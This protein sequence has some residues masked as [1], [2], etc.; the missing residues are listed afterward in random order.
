[1]MKRL[2]WLVPLLVA[3]QDPPPETWWNNDWGFRRRLE[4]RNSRPAPLAKGTRVPVALYR[5]TLKD[6]QSKS[7]EDLSD[8]RL[9]YGGREVPYE[10]GKSV[11]DV[12]VTFALAAELGA[13][14][15]REPY[16][17]DGGYCLYYGNKA[18]PAP[19]YAAIDQFLYSLEPGKDKLDDKRIDVDG[20]IAGEVDG[21]GWLISGLDASAVEGAPAAARLKLST[22]LGD[23]FRWLVE[24][25]SSGV[26]P[27]AGGY[28]GVEGGM[29]DP[30]PGDEER[31]TIDGLITALGN[32]DF[33][34]REEAT[35]ALVK[36]GR[37][38]LSQ[39]R[40]AA[41]SDDLEVQARARH[42]IG[43]IEA[44]KPTR[45]FS[46]GVRWQGGQGVAVGTLA[47]LAPGMQIQPQPIGKPASFAL[48]VYRNGTQFNLNCRLDRSSAPVLDSRLN[49]ASPDE[50]RLVLWGDGTGRYPALRIKRITL[51]PETNNA[52]RPQ[53][54][55]DMED[56][57]P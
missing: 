51:A 29:G 4:L 17:A 26:D 36:M 50:L 7:K 52:T 54:F 8:F 11:D 45:L 44:K 42:V 22:K 47:T 18:A 39:V 43:E 25:D 27:N 15:G 12:I 37:V 14:P 13:R 9:I 57:R 23:N 2:I 55:L 16:A 32:D 20:T 10:L 30:A 31:K 6:M 46:V 19:A 21:A 53:S 38:V 41:R 1:M 56:K 48:E 24:V 33:E 34:K 40:V 28:L 5:D 3:F 49:E 35:N